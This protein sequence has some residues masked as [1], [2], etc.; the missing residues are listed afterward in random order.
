MFFMKQLSQYRN[1]PGVQKQR[2][3]LMVDFPIPQEEWL[4][5]Q[6]EIISTAQD[7]M[8]I[9]PKCVMQIIFQ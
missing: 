3:K 5:N 4:K 1:F 6:L 8:N 9:T 7:I 2:L